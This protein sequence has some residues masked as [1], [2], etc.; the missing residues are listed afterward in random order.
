MAF[1]VSLPPLLIAACGNYILPGA[2]TLFI[3]LMGILVAAGLLGLKLRHEF[4]YRQDLGGSFKR[5]LMGIIFSILF[6][7]PYRLT[8]E[9]ILLGVIVFL[10]VNI[11]SIPLFNYTSWLNVDDAHDRLLWGEDPF[12]GHKYMVLP[13]RDI[14]KSAIVS[15]QTIEASPTGRLAICWE[16]LSLVNDDAEYCWRC[17]RTLRNSDKIYAT[18]PNKRPRDDSRLSS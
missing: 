16:C 1:L 15:G 14:S 7:I 13:S 6:A 11:I 2:W 9:S 10:A 8:V 3:I 12:Y 17:R 4:I 5:F 18:L